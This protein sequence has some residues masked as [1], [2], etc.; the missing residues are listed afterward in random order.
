MLLAHE[1]VA[2]GSK[3]RSNG[4]KGGGYAADALARP[5]FDAV[6]TTY[7]MLVNCADVFRK[8]AAWGYVVLDEACNLPMISPWSPGISSDLA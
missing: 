6:V 2:G 3:K 5:K 4:R 8:V 1:W 7:E